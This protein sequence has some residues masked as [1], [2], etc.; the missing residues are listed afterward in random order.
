MANVAQAQPID[1]NQPYANGPPYTVT[2][3]MIACGITDL[4]TA[5]TIAD[6]IF[7]DD[8]RRCKEK[9]EEKLQQDF[10][11][12]AGLTQA[13]GQIRLRPKTKDCIVAFNYWIKD[14]YRL[15]KEPSEHQFQATSTSAIFERAYT[16]KMFMEQSESL[17]TAAKPIKFET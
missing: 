4:A 10:K 11:T 5:T 1:P 12:F 6:E 13:Q 9:T 8:F 2:M 17:S 16:H 3:S 7:M 15:G 14:L